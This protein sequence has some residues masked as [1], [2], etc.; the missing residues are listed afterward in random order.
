MPDEWLERLD[1][2]GGAWLAETAR[3]MGLAGLLWSELTGEQRRMLPEN[4]QDTL[5]GL[6]LGTLMQWEGCRRL[7]IE[8][9]GRLAAADIPV[10][11]LKGS[12]LASTVYTDPGA[13]H[14]S[15][16]D[17][18]VPEDRVGDAQ[19]VLAEGA[20]TRHADIPGKPHPGA[21]GLP[22][23]LTRVEIHGDRT[24]AQWWAHFLDDPFDPHRTIDLGDASVTYLSPADQWMHVACHGLHHAVGCWPRTAADLSRIE[25]ADPWSDGEWPRIWEAACAV[26][27]RRS[28]LV[29]SALAG[30][31]R[32]HPALA[33]CVPD[34][35]L[36]TDAEARGRIAWRVAETSDGLTVDQWSRAWTV[37][38]PRRR[39]ACVRYIFPP[40]QLVAARYHTSRVAGV[41]GYPLFSM[42]RVVRLAF[43]GLRWSRIIARRR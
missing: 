17:V 26:D 16:V 7:L 33:A 42:S 15:D 39:R 6:H 36:V 29:A 27:R 28:V 1:E 13:R 38:A 40:V 5:R 35:A 22:L 11:A 8:A 30:A 34:R 14:M 19:D 2:A 4:A 25:K 20:E 18:L 24:H 12:A 41:L 3:A 21:I 32:V 37:D 31:G 23:Q 43:A 10:T 9:A